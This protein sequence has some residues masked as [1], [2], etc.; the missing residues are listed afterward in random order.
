M[1]KIEAN[2]TVKCLF[3]DILRAVFVRTSF[4]HF[5]LLFL[6]RHVY[7]KWNQLLFKEN[8]SAFLA[9]RTKK[10]PVEGWYKGELGFFDFYVIPLAKGS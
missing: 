9:G 10:S 1:Y 6:F 7:I 8:Y 3:D 5:L 2:L 4:A